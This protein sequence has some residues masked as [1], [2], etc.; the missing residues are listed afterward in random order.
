MTAI[1]TGAALISR[2]SALRT[3]L[4]IAAFALGFVGGWQVHGWRAAKVELRATKAQL[5]DVARETKRRHAIGLQ[6]AQDQ[7]DIEVFYEQLP[8]WW[9]TFVAERPALADA[10]L[11]PDGVCIWNRWNAGP[12]GGDRPCIAGEGAAAAGSEERPL[13]GSGGQPSTGDEG[14]PPERDAAQRADRYGQ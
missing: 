12:G 5:R 7:R 2:A 1:A 11:G 13:P 9:R 4:F 8:D 14:L 6:H 10:E 3:G